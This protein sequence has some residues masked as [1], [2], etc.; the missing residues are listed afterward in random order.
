MLR[1]SRGYVPAALT[2]PVP[3]TRPLLAC[4]AEQKSTFCLAG[5]A[6]AWVGHHIGDLEHYATLR[7]FRDGIDHFERLFALDARGGRPRPPSRL[8]LDPVRA[9]ARWGRARRGPAPPR[10]PGGLPGRARAV[11]AG[12]RRDL[13]RHRLRRRRHRLGRR[14]ARRRAARLRAR[15]LSAAGADA[16][17]RGGDPRAVADGVRLAGRGLRR[18]SAAS[19]GW[20]GAVDPARW[21]AIAPVAADR[22]LSPLTSSMGRLFDAVGALCGL[23]AGSA[24]RAR[25]RSC[26]RRPP[27]RRPADAGRGAGYELELGERDGVLVLDPRALVRAVDLAPSVAP[28]SR[29]R[30]RASTRRWR[31]RPRPALERVAGATGARHRGAQRRR[32][33]EPTAAAGGVR[34]PGPGGAPGARAR[35]AAA[36]TTAAS[37]SGRPRSPPPAPPSP[38]SPG[39]AR[40][41]SRSLRLGRAPLAQPDDRE[42][43]EPRVVARTG[44]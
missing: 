12:R 26:S 18:A 35:A 9:R 31:A 41:A 23:G 34:A 21:R 33:P 3:A 1:R 39:R 4:G 36:R 22:A 14:A 15:R 30:R 28:M 8:S 29:R 42:V 37:R 19:G 13:R 2:L 6:H 25:R 32:L 43:G 27:A 38:V 17:R 7:A 16:R 5:G 44:G 40:A 24:T 20:R 11:G 10:P